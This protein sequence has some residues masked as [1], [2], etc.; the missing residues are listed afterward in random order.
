MRKGLLRKME[1]SREN[2][3]RS[4]DLAREW[5]GESDVSIR[6]GAVHSAISAGYQAMFHAARAVLYVDGYREKSHYCVSRYLERYVESGELGKEWVGF[7]DRVRDIRHSDHYDLNF[8]NTSE[9]A[10]NVNGIA[11]SFIE[12]MDRLLKEKETGSP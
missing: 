4:L 11:R 9:D 3:I 10:V 8:V 12:R 1:P 6:S 5:L 2:G 7:L